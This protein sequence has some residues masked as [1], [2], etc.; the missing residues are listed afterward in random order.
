[1][2]LLLLLLLLWKRFDR[3]VSFKSIGKEGRVIVAWLRTIVWDY[4]KKAIFERESISKA[5]ISPNIYFRVL[6]KEL[7]ELLI[8]LYW[9]ILRNKILYIY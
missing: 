2:G 8:V 5:G 4:I 6:L 1:M 9:N 7:I 3:R